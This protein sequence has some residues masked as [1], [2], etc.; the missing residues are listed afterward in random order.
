[1]DDTE[2]AGNDC[3]LCEHVQFW[4]GVE[5]IHNLNGSADCPEED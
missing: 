4:D 5:F 3:P 1:M 2:W